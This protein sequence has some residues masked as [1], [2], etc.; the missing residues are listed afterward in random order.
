MAA[1]LETVESCSSQRQIN[2]TQS[3]ATSNMI[4]GLSFSQFLNSDSENECVTKLSKE[5]FSYIFQKVT[6]TI[7]S[8]LGAPLRE[9][10]LPTVAQLSD[11]EPSAIHYMEMLYE[12]ADSQQ[13]M[14]HVAEMLLERLKKHPQQWIVLVGDGKTYEH[15]LSMKRMY[16]SDFDKVLIF[17]GGWHI[18]KNFQ[19]VLMKVYYHAGLKDIASCSGYKA[20]TLNSL[21]KCSNFK[22]T[23]SF[24]MQV[25]EAMYTE[26]VISFTTANPH[27]SKLQQEIQF[28]ISSAQDTEVTSVNLLLSVQQLVKDHSAME[29]FDQFLIAKAN[30]DDTWKLWI[31]FV[32]HDCF[33]YLCLFLAIRNSNWD[34]RMSSLKAMAPLFAAYDKTCYEKLIP[35][36]LADVLNYPEKILK[37]FKAGGFTVSSMVELVMQ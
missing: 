3:T 27:F 18:L 29:E 31:N 17:P 19:P 10:L 21:E 2:V 34:L 28:Q 13:T 16:G 4:P 26:I 7:P 6:C 8:P 14:C 11:K 20:E 22:R 1:S 23:H 35:H 9:F 32:F 5:A 30:S 37:C 33:S 15:L 12:N 36:H 25:W 24:L